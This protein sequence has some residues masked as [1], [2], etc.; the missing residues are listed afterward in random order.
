MISKVKSKSSFASGGS[1]SR[2]RL[3][4]FFKPRPAITA[5]PTTIA[6]G[7]AFSVDTPTPGAIAEVVLLRAGAVTH[8]FNQNQRYVG[9]TITG[10][11]AAAVE[12]TA[13]PDGTIATGLLPAFPRRPRPGAFRGELDSVKSMSFKT[14]RDRVWGNRTGAQI[15]RRRDYL[16][17]AWLTRP[18]ERFT[19]ALVLISGH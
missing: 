13:P 8:G 9:C 19:N 1:A 3:T 7:A 4:N 6:H 15:S 10:T 2:A 5:S 18:S 12:A 14:I 11:T 17:P 16:P